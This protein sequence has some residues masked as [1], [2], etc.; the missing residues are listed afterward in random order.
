MPP[1]N[2]PDPPKFAYD[3]LLP[4]EMARRAENIG[5]AKAK[6]DAVSLLTLAVLAGAF[7]ALGAIFMTTTLTGSAGHLPFGVARLL[8]GVVFALGLVLVV[9]GGAELFTGNNLMVMAWASRRVSST[10]L[11]R[12]WTVAYVGN[13]IAAS[14]VA[15]MAFFAGY[16][17]F[18]QSAIG[19]TALRIAQ[20]KTTLGFTEAFFLG[21]L[22]NILVCLAVW[23]TYSAHTVTGK[24][25]V[26]VPPVAAFVA[27]GFEHSIA[28]M[29]LIP[30]GLLIKWFAEP[31]FW[32]TI[33][34]TPQQFPSLTLEGA[35]RNL[36]PVTLGNIVGGGVFVAA[37]YWFVYLRKR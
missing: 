18:G 23:L 25:L 22:C 3:P 28:N 32:Q 14:G 36:L 2:Q 30:A 8:G 19:E 35:V 15:I 34:A 5:I 1:E 37:V 12:S 11:L 16:Y 9:I 20:A 7:I 27:A 21:I 26:I 4:P 13:F 10:A 33:S 29:Y 31:S 6:L 24:I 17:S